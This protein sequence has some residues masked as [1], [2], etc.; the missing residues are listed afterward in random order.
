MVNNWQEER[1]VFFLFVF[2]FF[3][4][5]VFCLFRAAL[6]A[7]K[8][9]RLGIKSELELPAYTTATAMEGIRAAFATY[10]TAHS[11]TRSL[12]HWTRP[13]VKSMFSW[14]L[15]GFMTTEPRVGT[16][17]IFIIL[18]CFSFNSQLNVYILMNHLSHC[19]CLNTSLNDF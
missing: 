17:K 5:L 11:S 8:V 9:P 18:N 1:C 16:P 13:G 6:V 2:L 10:T 19:S 14:I 7:Q 15:V 12:T 3:F 4:F